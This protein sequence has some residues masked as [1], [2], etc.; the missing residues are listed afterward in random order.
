MRRRTRRG[1]KAG[2]SRR[3]YYSRQAANDSA[4]VSE[5]TASTRGLQDGGDHVMEKGF[6]GGGGMANKDYIRIYRPTRCLVKVDH[7]LFNQFVPNRH[8]SDDG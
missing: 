6:R 3:A 4:A 7:Q 8:I 1:T 5:N 2:Q